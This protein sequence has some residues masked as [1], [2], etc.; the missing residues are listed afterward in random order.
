MSAEKLDTP[1]LVWHLLRLAAQIR[2]IRSSLA[3]LIGWGT[4]VSG[5]LME[6]M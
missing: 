4:W 1:F 2:Y 3:V 6:L 5:F